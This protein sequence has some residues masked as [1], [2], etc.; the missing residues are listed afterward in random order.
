MRALF[1]AGLVVLIFGVASLFVTFP[2]KERHGMNAG[3]VSVG[4]ETQHNEKLA[5][6]VSAGLILA[7]AGMMI[8]SRG[9]A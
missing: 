6:I 5:P 8:A 4:I 7:G 3:G 1:I 9:R 2:Q